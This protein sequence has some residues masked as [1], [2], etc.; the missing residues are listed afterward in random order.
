MRNPRI[1]AAV[2]LARA[3]LHYKR[4]RTA[5]IYSLFTIVKAICARELA[6]GVHP[7]LDDARGVAQMVQEEAVQDLGFRV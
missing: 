2:R 7:E 4:V 5:S 6:V 3:N 1:I